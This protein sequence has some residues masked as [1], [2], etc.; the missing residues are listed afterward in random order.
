MALFDHDRIL[1]LDMGASKIALAEFQISKNGNLELMRYGINPTGAETKSES[2]KLAYIVTA[3]NDI[4]REQGIRPAP[5]LMTVSGQ[6]V[7]PDL[8]SFP[9]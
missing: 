6:A 3:I 5:M 8:S 7:F 2:D 9:P 1:A 4:M